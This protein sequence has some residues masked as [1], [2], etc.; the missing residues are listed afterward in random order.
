MAVECGLT[1]GRTQSVGKTF[2]LK[3][4]PDAQSDLTS[5]RLCLI[6]NIAAKALSL[7]GYTLST[8]ENCTDKYMFTS[9][10]EGSIDKGYKKYIC[11]VV[12][13]FETN[14]KEICLTWEQYVK[15]KMNQ[16]AEFSEYKFIES[17]RNNTKKDFFLR[18][19]ANAIVIFELMAVKP[20]RP[21]IIG[22]NNLQDNRSIT[23]TRGI[24][25]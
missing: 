2:N 11:G 10:S 12:K 18:N 9:K 14:S 5:H 3:Y 8:E 23:N 19:L 7:H 17:E 25:L 21:V 13:N 1:F 16:L 15:C 20:S 22:N 24:C 6:K 4:Q